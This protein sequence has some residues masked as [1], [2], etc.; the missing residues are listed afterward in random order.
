MRN[1]LL[2]ITVICFSLSLSAQQ[3]IYT[4]Q[5]QEI[6]SLLVLKDL[7]KTALEKV[8]ILYADAKQKNIQDEI[9]KAL[10][11]K[12]SI[13]DKIKDNDINQRLTLLNNEL[14][15]ANDKVSKS[16]LEILLANNL[17]DYYKGNFWKNNQRK[18]TINFKEADITTWTNQQLIQ[19]IDSL[20][21]EAL[22]QKKLLQQTNITYVNAI[23]IKGNTP[24]SRSTLYD[25][26]A[27]EELD[28]YKTDLPYIT[29]AAYTFKLND[30]HVLSGMNEFIQYNFFSQDTASH[31]LKA[32]KLFQQLIQFHL[33]DADPSALI[34]VDLERIQWTYNLVNFENKEVLYKN[35][36]LNI[37]NKFS[38]TKPAAE[39]W[40]KLI[41]L[42]A[43]K[44]N[45][46][47]T[48]NDTTERYGYVKVK[49]MIEE[50]LKAV[51]DS[52]FG[53]DEMKQLLVNI[54]KPGLTTQAESVNVANAPFRIFVQYM[55]IDTLYAHV[56]LQKDVNQAAKNKNY[57]KWKD[58]VALA[59]FKTF[60]QL[61]P[62]TNDYQQHAVEI[63]ADALPPGHYTILF[64]NSKD[65][66]NKKST[67]ATQEFIVSRLSYMHN[68]FDYFVV[69]R[70]TGQP[71]KNVKA[72]GTVEV[73]DQKKHTWATKKLKPLYTDSLG[74]FTIA[75][76]KKKTETYDDIN[77]KIEKD[78][79]LLETNE[80][81]YSWHSYNND[82][83]ENDSDYEDDNS[84]V[85]FFTDRS[86][87]RPGQTIFYKGIVI[88][89]DRKTK[90]NKLYH[91]K[92]SVK[93]DLKDA[94][95]KTIDSMFIKLNEYGSFN[96]KFE[97]PQNVLTGEFSIETFDFEE[98]EVNFNV[99]EYKRPTFYVEFDTLKNSYR[100]NDT[101]TITGFAKAYNGAAIDNAKLNYTIQRSA[102]FPYPYLF[103]NTRTPY[104]R[105]T[106]IADSS[107]NTDANG[108]FQI[109][110]VATPDASVDKKT[111]PLFN[112][113][114]E[115][116]VTDIN[117]ETREAKTIAQVAYKSMVLQVN[118]PEIA[119]AHNFKNIFITTKNNAGE[120]IPA[121]VDV[122]ISL[123]Q[124]PA[125]AY[126]KRLWQQPDQFVMS[127]EV[128]ATYFPYDEY[129]KEADCHEWKKL[130]A[131]VKDTFN[132]ASTSDYKLKTGN[133][134]QGWYCIEARTKDKDGNEVKDVRYIQVYDLSAAG[135]PSPQI[136]FS[137]A[138]SNSGT[139]GDKT[140][141]LLGT[142]ETNVFAIEKI[143]SGKNEAEDS[144]NYIKLDS[145]KK[146]IEYAIKPTD[147]D[148]VGLYYA[149]IKHNSFYTGGMQVYINHD[150][151]NLNITYASFRNKSEPGS[152]ETFTV[153]V[154]NN[155]GEK[156]DAE[157]LTSM[158]D[159]SLDQFKKQQWEIPYFNETHDISNEWE[160]K[161]F[162]VA[163]S[164]DNYNYEDYYNRF[165]KEYDHIAKSANEL[166][167]VYEYE[168]WKRIEI[169]KYTPPKVV[170]DNEVKQE[171]QGKAMGLSLNE[172]VITTA[173]GIRSKSEA[174]GYSIASLNG[175]SIIDTSFFRT[176]I[177]GITSV[178]NIN[179]I[180]VIID[181]VIT[182]KKI[183][184]IDINEIDNVTVL[185]GS[186]AVAVYGS[187][188]ANGAIVITTKEFALR[189]SKKKEQESQVQ[190]RKNFNETAFF[191]PNL[192]A[193]STGN[194]SFSFTMPD[195]LT[196]WKWMS[197]A[198]TKDLAFG[199]KEQNI[200]TQKTLMVQP[201]MPRFLRA[202]DKIELTAKI[203]NLSDSII[204]GKASA[205]LMD[206]ITNKPLNDSFRINVAEQ[207]FTAEPDRS[208]VVKFPVTI[209]VNYIHPLT[210]KI[211]GLSNKYSDGEEN[212]LP[213][214]SNRM[215]VT[216]TLPL[217]MPGEGSKEFKFSK[218]A[219]DTSST[220]T[221]ES[222]T[223]EYTPNPVWYA[224]QS[225]PYL[226]LFPHECAEQIFNR[227]Y[228]NAL[229]A[230]I[231]AKYPSI[232]EAFEKWK[233]STVLESD[234]GK[235][236][237]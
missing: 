109:R 146:Q 163:N 232:K 187:K 105:S 129:E 65:F 74:R 110:F 30:T 10:L 137:H 55:N 227:F 124:S 149:F 175:Q 130:D 40:Y 143:S 168:R 210:I 171:L 5:W 86:I 228:A 140:Q 203:T 205:Q 235:T 191:Y 90:Q 3:D 61:L 60:Q 84:H 116:S 199:L 174:L 215:L 83:D 100:L 112:F 34:D 132:T 139:P 234:L 221:N 17:N 161:N 58:I 125:K 123:L 92:D 148:N 91:Y 70:E 230:H 183:E 28:Y 141:L 8:N 195:A 6:D 127:R 194:Y 101:I 13:D 134:K 106:Q 176:K 231:V 131:V 167:R 147:Y 119:D 220:L 181:G 135:L 52:C 93:V 38:N 226:M 209:P 25:L 160:A 59:P 53:N 189:N 29:Q 49:R 1:I 115:L 118:V 7:P 14:K 114:I 218:L 136:N 219:N 103:W 2:L 151:K 78:N 12:L 98:G 202:G 77:I 236:K 237:S 229:A 193:D 54:L 217:Y 145:N 27:H 144:F 35:A 18:E 206:A 173:L 102:N 96:G 76:D 157:L 80:Q 172:A 75:A 26:I 69:D 43:D 36:L 196:K 156:A 165:E 198:H 155:K 72:T 16:I 82:E 67:L 222:L 88:T 31:L 216:E 47:E 180:L 95:R 212:T 41:E 154:N 122:H 184:A 71:I 48:L 213:V 79:D 11:Y 42:E 128:Y 225:L 211:V 162:E 99:E 32:L 201:N 133:L 94:N 20:F 39:A 200:I 166:W 45:L 15:T 120:N 81:L 208:T 233:D 121:K 63:K 170:N 23:I 169:T 108:K 204:N 37:T 24:G 153:T 117:G 164:D 179:D 4:K 186:E 56:L 178:S 62:Q 73:K 142:S 33:T 97:L 85:Y 68:G 44:A 214:L 197:L 50:R 138:I 177:R 126:R 207:N 224:V 64:S 57:N 87:Y 22:S 46:Y 188:A 107:I 192:Y 158:Y 21:D 223:V 150:E 111:E 152:K 182:D 19:T 51:P 104:S 159:A 185:K 89:K 66:D 113:N 190:L 9:I